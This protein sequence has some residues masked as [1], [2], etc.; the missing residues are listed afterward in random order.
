MKA[1][2]K[3]EHEWL[4]LLAEKKQLVSHGYPRLWELRKQVAQMNIELAIKELFKNWKE[5]DSAFKNKYRSYK[6]KYLKSLK[7]KKAE[8]IGLGK[9]REMLLEAGYKE[10]WKK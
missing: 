3:Q 8:K 9:I 6:S 10:D 1:A 2:E 4:E 7:D 5:Q